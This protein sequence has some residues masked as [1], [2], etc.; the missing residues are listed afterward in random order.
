[1][2]W[3]EC[4]FLLTQAKVDGSFPAT[5]LETATVGLIYAAW[6][7]I[8]EESWSDYQSTRASTVNY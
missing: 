2:C 7:A 6:L 5:L 1:M 3:A 4:S 8:T